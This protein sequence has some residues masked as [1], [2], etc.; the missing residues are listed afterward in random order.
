M[1]EF[2]INPIEIESSKWNKNFQDSHFT[3][4]A[5]EVK[6][7]LYFFVIQ[8]FFLYFCKACNHCKDNLFY[9]SLERKEAVKMN[10]IIYSKLKGYELF[11]TS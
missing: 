9:L 2:L 6:R 8:D 3:F 5:P 4:Q 7:I 10:V 11:K 1:I